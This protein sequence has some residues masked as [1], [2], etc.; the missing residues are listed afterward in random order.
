MSV[1]TEEPS[2]TS[3]VAGGQDEL[4][5]PLDVSMRELRRAR[6]WRRLIL[7]LLLAFLV[8]GALNFFGLRMAKT[9]ASGNGYQLEVS[10]PKTGRPGIGAPLQIQIQHDNGFQGPVT[11]SMSNDYLDVLDVRS[12]QPSPS[13]T[14]STDKAQIW[15]FNQPPGDTLSVSVSAEF[16]PDEHPG[17]H[18]GTISVLDNGKPAAQVQFRTWEAP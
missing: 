11:V 2:S 3:T 15:Q 18:D 4:G 10:Y 17:S 6:T 5:A 7:I 12:I 8:L 13:Q 1:T 9:S 16:E 14:T